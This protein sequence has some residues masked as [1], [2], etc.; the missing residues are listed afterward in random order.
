MKTLLVHA[1]PEPHSYGAALRDRAVAALTGAGHE[2]QVSDLYAMGFDPV[3]RDA[4]FTARR[5]PE[6][7]QYDREQKHASAHGTFAPDIRAEIEK[8]L[9]SDLLVLQFPLWW[10]SVPAI[11][12]GWLDRVLANGVA[13]GAGRR[14]EHGMLRGRSAMIAMTTGC[15]ERM[16]APDGLLGDVEVMLWPLQFGVLA[17]TGLRVLPPWVGWNL[18]YQTPERQAAYLDEY[19]AHLLRAEQLPPLFFHPQ[20]D[21]GADW[22]LEPGIEA[23]TVAQRRRA[24][25]AAD[26]RPVPPAVG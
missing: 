17:Y 8:L 21:F 24:R 13:Y 1:H 12:K 10:F 7:L 5:F 9:W 22:R 20:S 2:V 25:E 4:D 19:A 3:A 14:L 26:L 23:E 6:R 18:R 11:M 15:D 16:M